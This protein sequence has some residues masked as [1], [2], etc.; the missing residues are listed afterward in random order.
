MAAP[1]GTRVLGLVSAAN[2]HELGARA[3]SAKRSAKD[4]GRKLRLNA[5]STGDVHARLLEMA[6]AT[7]VDA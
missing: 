6:D 2:A 3:K 5:I 1:S 7:K 4:H